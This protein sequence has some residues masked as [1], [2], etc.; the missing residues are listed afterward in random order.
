M[1]LSPP[2]ENDGLNQVFAA[3][4]GKT[5]VRQVLTGTYF[6]LQWLPLPSIWLALPCSLKRS[7]YV[8]LTPRSDWLPP[9]QLLSLGSLKAAAVGWGLP[10]PLT[11]F[12]STLLSL[13]LTQQ[14]CLH[15]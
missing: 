14:S 3:W 11:R 15:P 12:A 2:F 13:V 7:D 5:T 1:V 8:W 4:S 6:W 10:P 9:H